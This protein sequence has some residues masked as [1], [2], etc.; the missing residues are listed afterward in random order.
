MDDNT[1]SFAIFSTQ[2][3]PALGTLHLAFSFILR[4]WKKRQKREI[5]TERGEW[6]REESRS[7]ACIKKKKSFEVMRELRV[8]GKEEEQ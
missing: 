8:G 5:A 1:L 4:M 6:Q 3:S 2:S 7:G